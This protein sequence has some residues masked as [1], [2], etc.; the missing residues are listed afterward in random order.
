MND[1]RTSEENTFNPEFPGGLITTELTE[2]DLILPRDTRQQVKILENWLL[3]RDAFMK[4]WNMKR[5]IKPG[6]RVLFYGPHGT[7]KTLTA[8]IL[9]RIT[10]KEVYRVDLNLVVSK[11]IGETEKNLSLLF[12]RAEQKDWILFFDEADALFGKRTNV[13]EGHDRYANQEV[14]YIMKRV[15]KH[16]G[17]VIFASDRKSVLNQIFIRRL[18]LIVNFPPPDAQG[19]FHLWKKVLPQRSGLRIPSDEDLQLLASKYEINGAGI[20][21]VVQNCC[22][23]ALADKSGEITIDGLQE[24]IAREHA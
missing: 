4:E 23:E 7:G 16:K 13:R 24:G 9:G 18:Q 2:E 17:L 8:T 1:I 22:L 12:D 19:R 15:E 20:V 10:G 3:H 5:W 21:N 6:Y 14:S 11:Y